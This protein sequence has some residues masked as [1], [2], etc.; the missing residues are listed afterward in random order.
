MHCAKWSA[1][2]RNAPRKN[3]E[4]NL[5]NE[6]LD[7]ATKLLFKENRVNLKLQREKAALVAEQERLDELLSKF[8][9][10]DVLGNTG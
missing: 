8:L 4:I 1:G 5:L 7:T 10:A 3:R 9:V 6:S 2:I